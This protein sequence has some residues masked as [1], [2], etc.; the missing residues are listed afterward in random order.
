MQM[1]P[2]SLTLRGYQIGAE[3]HRSSHTV[4]YRGQQRQPSR[5]V[6]LKTL[7]ESPSTES[8]ARLHHEYAILKALDIEGVIKTY[9]L[10]TQRR[11]PVLVLEDVGGISLKTYGATRSLGLK[12]VLEIAV[13]LAEILGK[14]H[15][16]QVIHRDI[17]P[18]NIVINPVSR[19]VTLVDFAIAVRHNGSQPNF[20]SAE[21]MEGTLA[22]MS[23]EQTGRMNRT[24]DYRTDFYSLG[25]TLYELLC[26]HLPFEATDP[27]EVVHCHIARQPTPI[28]HFNPDVPDPIAKIVMKLLAKM[29]DDRY[30]S[31]WGIEVDLVFCLMQYE[32]TGSIDDFTPG[33]H[34]LSDRLQIP[35]KLYGRSAQFQELLTI[36]THVLRASGQQATQ[37]PVS[38][39]VCGDACSTDSTTP[40]MGA[41][42]TPPSALSL[43]SMLQTPVLVLVSGYSGC[44]KSSLVRELHVPVLQHRGYFAWGGFVP[45]QQAAPRSG[46]MMALRSLLRQIL[47]ESDTH[48]QQ[49]RTQLLTMFAPGSVS[50]SVPGSTPGSAF[51]FSSEV[52][53]NT[54]ELLAYLPELA[55]VLGQAQP[56]GMTCLVKEDSLN[57]SIQRLL[58]VIC[59]PQH[60]LVLFLDD[61]QWADE[62]SLNL[63]E[64]LVTDTSLP[65]LVLI[66]AYRSNEISSGHPLLAMLVN[67]HGTGIVHHIPLEPLSLEA[68]TELLMESLHQSPQ[69]VA[70]LAGVVMRKTA[71]NPRFIHEFLHTLYDQDLIQFDFECL[72]WTWDLQPIAALQTTENL[73]D[74]AVNKLTKLPTE[75]QYILQSAACV[76]T[77]FDLNTLANIVQ[78]SV[79][80]IYRNLY[81]AVQDGLVMSASEQEFDP[82]KPTVASLYRFL[83]TRIQQAAYGLIPIGDR[84]ALHLR[85]GRILLTT[86]PSV[87]LD[88]SLFDILNH[89]NL[90]I[91]L[92]RDPQERW[93]LVQLNLLTGRK[94]NSAAAYVAATHYFNAG[95]KLLPADCWQ[96]DYD[97]ALTFHNEAAIANFLAT[98][99]QMAIDL[100][101][102][103]FQ[104]ATALLDQIT[105]CEVSL[106]CFT[107]R[108]QFPEALTLAKAILSQLGVNL[109]LPLPPLLPDQALAARKILRWVVPSA[110]SLDFIL[111]QQMCQASS[112]LAQQLELASLLDNV[113]DTVLGM[114]QDKP[115][116]QHCA[117]LKAMSAMGMDT[118]NPEIAARCAV[119]YCYHLF[120]SGES[121]GTIAQ[122][123]QQ[124]RTLVH[125]LKQSFFES[126]LAPWQQLI[127]NLLENCNNPQQLV[128]NY[129][130]EVASLS[131]FQL[132]GNRT[133]LYLTYLAKA[134]LAYLF[135]APAQGSIFSTL[136]LQNQDAVTTDYIPSSQILHSLMLL[137]SF[138][139]ADPQQQATI[140]E[141]ISALQVAVQELIRDDPDYFR[142]WGALI[143]AEL[144]RVQA[145][146]LQAMEYYDRALHAA[147]TANLP[148]QE[149]IAAER[150]ALFYQSLGRQSI[151]LLYLRRA[152][153]SYS[154]WGAV[155]KVRQLEATY[156]QILSAGHFSNDGSFPLTI[157]SSTSSARLLDFASVL[158][159]SQVLAGEI[160]L[161]RL[162]EK[163]M[164]IAIE[165]V[166]A[167]WGSLLLE[168]DGAWAVA[169]SG[170]S[171]HVT[172]LPRQVPQLSTH[173][174][175]PPIPSPELAPALSDLPDGII[176][177]VLRTRTH[178]VLDDAAQAEQFITDAYIQTYQPKS[179]LCTPLV[180]QNKLSGIL[181]LENNLTI[182]AFTPDRLEVLQ[183]LSSQIAI[184]IENAQL[185]SN[186]QQFTQNLE[187]LVEERTQALSQTLSNLQAAQNK[188]V[189]SEKMAALGGL[190]AG[191][192]HE[193]NTPIGIGVTAASLLAD[194]TAKFVQ[195]YHAGKMKRLDL[196]A[197]LEIARQSSAMILANLTRAADLI[198]SFKQVAIDQSTEE[199]R[200]FALRTYLDET[201]L[202]L[203]PKLK[204]TTHQVTIVGDEDI[205]LESY[206]GAFSQIIT[207]LVMN[208]LLHAYNPGDQG[209]IE[210]AI[211]QENNNLTLRYTDDGNG[212]SPENISKIFDPFF[213]T[214]RGQGGSGL[215]LHII[216]NLVTQKLGGTI[217]CESVL[218]EGT[219]FLITIPLM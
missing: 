104:N 83:H 139:Q 117:D 116:R 55:M 46:I 137:A 127:Q 129:F 31:A 201:L 138:P 150:A 216:Y 168:Q 86:T 68:I 111:F 182:G 125:R 1:H 123:Y 10:E 94:A 93:Q 35:Q 84:A 60:P 167:E 188:L 80:E 119:D 135:N 184:S 206:P 19:R 203:R 154:R 106:R 205:T 42:A 131:T 66:G 110:Q 29:A 8:I 95:L 204:G 100:A 166:G 179:V 132:Q 56:T 114:Q 53:E 59:Q 99:L 96:T 2:P 7:T 148:Q 213:T 51:E 141:Q 24:V 44:G 62:P 52:E 178:V 219:S 91:D 209:Q 215:G 143:Q 102:V 107:A 4:I 3:L 32:A 92:I 74:L 210:I 71:G 200:R 79:A 118:G 122:D 169:A 30:Q 161:D 103:V 38:E 28:H 97:T 157:S 98:N 89:L 155:A 78:C 73:I 67:V 87:A 175:L 140:L 16:Q 196:E 120:W 25:V 112:A 134:Y 22:Y 173:P 36:S 218:G 50:G 160:I 176:N 180:H 20:S 185:Y 142:G 57:H 162:L 109:G 82:A 77:W 212:I 34:D 151:T 194:R 17:K 81:P 193:I 101:D 65:H 190:V 181:Y 171:T 214:R 11:V 177:Y 172:V 207:N 183:L 105:A 15:Q 61:L 208:S 69:A 159:A 45:D 189:E 6:V 158:K 163:L 63:I 195:T 43:P 187:N 21:V 13:Q 174:Q 152:H 149:A 113:D 165:N 64:Q 47:S 76:G 156:P 12:D 48:L 133:L 18:S 192:A 217:R 23:P 199:R 108:S 121:L 9:G 197:F 54:A 39:A 5:P 27:M 33:E 26:H 211:H 37:Q 202:S 164:Q 88:D 49:W 147:Y 191:V 14:L 126:C 40:A 85:V 186:L 58:Q 153:D 146:P 136:A 130:N 145:M 41:I 90:G 75:T 198:H 170:D 144:A 70:P 115:I 128:G 72:Q 124:Q